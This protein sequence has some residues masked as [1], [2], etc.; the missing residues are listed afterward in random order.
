[1]ADVQLGTGLNA[2]QSGGWAL[3]V[4]YEDSNQ[5]TRNLTIFDGFKFVLADGPPVD[6]P[7]TGFTTPQSGPVTTTRRAR[8]A[9]R[10]T[11]A[12]PATPPPSTAG[13]PSANATRRTP[14]TT[15]STP[16]S[17]A[18]SP[19]TSLHREGPEPPQPV[20]LRR[21]HLRRDRVPGQ[22]PELDHLRLRR[23][24]TA[25]P[26]TASASPPTSSLP[27]LR[28]TK[29]VDK[30]RPSSA[31]SS[32]TRSGSPTRASTRPTNTIMHDVIP[33]GSTF[34]PGSLSIVEGA[35]AGAKTDPARRRPG[36]VRRRPATQVVLPP[37]GAAPTPPTAAGGSRSTTRR[38]S[39]SRSRSPIS[40]R[41]GRG[42]QQRVRRAT[43]P[44]RSSKPGAVTS[45]DVVTTDEVPDLAIAKS[46]TGQFQS[47]RT[48]RSRGRQQRGRRSSRGR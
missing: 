23:A 21:R 11:S 19:A 47:G 15:S 20:R 8:R 48:S 45:P 18:A 27:S 41:R 12:R 34:V 7:L 17:P 24:A 5:P 40:W 2:D 16:R 35:N 26:P 13:S 44:R 31:T 32:L 6:I 43:S 22:R 9:S 30:T 39:A 4:A 33:A 37:R 1:M 3:A 36:R 38:A 14:Q 10:A 42:R 28:V 46:H 25:T 29:S